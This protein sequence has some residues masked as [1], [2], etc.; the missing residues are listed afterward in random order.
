VS[1]A[2]PGKPASLIVGAIADEYPIVPRTPEQVAEL[3]ARYRPFESAGAWRKLHVDEPRWER[4]SRILRREIDD[5]GDQ[6]WRD[7]QD[8]LIRATAL[9]ST[10]LDGLVPANPELTTMVLASSI[11]GRDDDL[12]GAIEV[13]A[14]CNRRALILAGEAALAGRAIDPNFIALLQD[15]I[16]E[17]QAT[18]TVTTESNVEVEVELPRRQ[19]KPVT[20]YLVRSSGGVAVFAPAGRVAAEMERLSG[21]LASADFVA[22]HPVAQ[23]A[24][25][26]YA[27]L[28]IHPF[29]DGNGRLA[30]TVASIWL[31]RATGLPLLVFGDQWPRYYQAVEA[32]QTGDPQTIVDFVAEVGIST[33]DIAVGLLG[34]PAV[35]LLARQ[36]RTRRAPAPQVL[37]DGARGALRALAGELREAL[38]SPP[39]GMRIAI[40]ETRSAPVGHIESAYR[41]VEPDGAGR[42]G[43][44]VAIRVDLPRQRAPTVAP[45]VAAA[46]AG[47]VA[48]QRP[49]V[50]SVDLEFVALVSQMPGDLLPIALRETRG[51]ELLEFALTDV[52]PLV[53]EPASLRIRLWVRRLLNDALAPILP[54]PKRSDASRRAGASRPPSADGGSS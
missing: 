42:F 31:I 7:V 15:V 41:V 18:Y 29:A 46:S 4:Y 1:D 47:Q 10:A 33:M 49:P 52:Y 28:T 6:A 34:R 11:Q 37:E 14:E 12:A 3:E 40:G 44:A 43:L 17:S 32:C 9:D 5:A 35:P 54:A 16:T 23:S 25:V 38:V 2:L 50:A 36:R 39:R 19:Y 53:L 22:L 30:R 27:L 20:N 24:Y 8:R 51:K 45:W 13:V 21:E 48:A 26:V